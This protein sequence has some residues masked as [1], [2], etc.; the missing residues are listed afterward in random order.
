M[1]YYASIITLTWRDSCIKRW[2]FSTSTLFHPKFECA[3]LPNFRHFRHLHSSWKGFDSG[4]RMQG[5]CLVQCSGVHQQVMAD[6]WSVRTIWIA[7]WKGIDNLNI[8]EYRPGSFGR[9]FN[10]WE[11]VFVIWYRWS[12][13]HPSSP[14]CGETAASR[15]SNFWRV[16][17]II[18]RMSQLGN[19]ESKH[20]LCTLRIQKGQ[21]KGLPKQF[22]SSNWAEREDQTVCHENTCLEITFPLLISTLH[23]Q[24]SKTLQDLVCKAYMA[25]GH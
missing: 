1:S 23:P 20:H 19:P 22:F 2:Q 3:T 9:V 4:I 16:P 17:C 25:L 14:F 7:R 5:Y 12:I 6:Q 18:Q 10:T 24:G 11:R 8:F 13:M 15:D 21:V